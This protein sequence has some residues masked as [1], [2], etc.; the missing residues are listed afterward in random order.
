MP[1]A[2]KQG[3]EKDFLGRLRNLSAQ[4]NS[5]GV[6]EVNY[7]CESGADITASFGE[8]SLRQSIVRLPRSRNLFQRKLI[9]NGA[10]FAG[11]R[12]SDSL[13]EFLPD[14]LYNG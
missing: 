10:G 2:V 6:Q 14:A 12:R 9:G 11:E 13:L 7:R 3:I 8:N 4:D 1:K 5:F